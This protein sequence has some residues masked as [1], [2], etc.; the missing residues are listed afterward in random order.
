LKRILTGLFLLLAAPLALAQSWT[1]FHPGRNNTLSGAAVSLP[2]Q[3]EIVFQHNFYDGVTTPQVGTGIYT[4]SGSITYA[5]ASDAISEAGANVIPIAIRY[6]GTEPMKGAYLGGAITNFITRSE[7]FN[8]ASWTAIGGGSASANTATDP[9]GTSTADTI[10]GSSTGDGIAFASGQ[11]AASR[12]FI[13]SVRFKTSTGT[14]TPKI[15]IKDGGI[16]GNFSECYATTAWTKEDR[17][18]VPFTFSSAASGN[19][20]VQI[21]VGNSSNVRAWG[22]QLE[23]FGTGATVGK[24]NRFSFANPYV[25][26]SGASAASGNSLY[27]IPNSI[28][29]QIA[30]EGTFAGWIYNEWDFTDINPTGGGNAP[31]FFST[32]GENLALNASSTEGLKFWYNN[33]AAVAL[34]S[35]TTYGTIGLSTHQWT[36]VIVSWN[37]VTDVYKMYINGSPVKTDT[38]ARTTPTIGTDALNLGGYL[39]GTSSTNNADLGADALM[40]QT[41]FWKKQL[42]DAEAAQVYNTKKSMG[43][44]STPG[45]GQLFAVDL[46]TSLI[47]T[48]GDKRVYFGARKTGVPIY[49]PDSI[50]TLKATTASTYPAPAYPLNGTN[51]GGFYF[52][53]PTENLILQ[54]EDIETTWAAVGTITRDNNVA[55]FLGTVSYGTIVA[56]NTEGI[57]QT[58]AT[59]VASTAWTASVYGSVASGTLNTR[60]TLEGSSGGTPQTTNCDFTLTTTPE[61]YSCYAAFTSGATGNI[62]MSFTHRATGTSRVGGLQLERSDNAGQSFWKKPAAY[63]KTT[64]AAVRTGWNQI[65][66]SGADSFNIL[67][68]TAIA[69]G[70]LWLDESTDGL[71]ADG[72]TIIAAPGQFSNFYWHIG[73]TGNGFEL[74]YGTI[75]TPLVRVTPYAST[76]GQYYQYGVT[77]D[78]TVSPAQFKLYVDGAEVAS[79]TSSSTVN[80]LPRKFI[81]GGDYIW[82]RM[83]FWH[84]A[85]DHIEVWGAPNPTAILDDWN[86]RKTSYGR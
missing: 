19:V 61:R 22:A 46:G 47:P 51:K 56:D 58:V 86:A 37:S 23:D 7:E 28:L 57:T 50:N 84:G 68:G 5:S 79:T 71:P 54:S 3:S 20:S 4:R 21:I 64:T 76:I 82:G 55:N 25:R 65:V 32:G 39:T 30:A 48:V 11:A 80:M 78:Q 35:G 74:L 44:R 70:F 1:K 59:S 69:W 52:S 2:Q 27:Q 67:K 9:M 83:D 45:T 14:A 15:I 60:L 85:L 77:W 42:T 8:H 81:V 53:G 72:P 41:I 17:C 75:G 6:G 24:R 31:Y 26:T 18:E 73:P 29:T 34:N 12:T 62:K 16:E 38:T 36:H 49:F 43:Q 33:A 13:F 63:M 10:S 66:Y 40:S